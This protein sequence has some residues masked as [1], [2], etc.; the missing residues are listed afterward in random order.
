M[1]IVVMVSAVDVAQRVPYRIDSDTVLRKF[2]AEM[3]VH[4]DKKGKGLKG[5]HGVG[6]KRHDEDADVNDSCL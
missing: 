3:A 5:E 6:V 2:V 1:V 4:I